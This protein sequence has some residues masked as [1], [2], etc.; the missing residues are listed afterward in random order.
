MKKTLHI[1][2]ATYDALK[3]YADAKRL[4][5]EQFIEKLVNVNDL[6]DMELEPRS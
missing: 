2:S 5:V 1:D 6:S 4:T 3:S